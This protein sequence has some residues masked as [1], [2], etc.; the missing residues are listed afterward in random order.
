MYYDGRS[1]KQKESIWSWIN[2]LNADCY[3]WG[4]TDVPLW[5]VLFVI[6][7]VFAFPL[8]IVG[9]AFMRAAYC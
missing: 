5:F 4:S 9:E 6:P 8:V 1:E 2:W 3:V 7:L